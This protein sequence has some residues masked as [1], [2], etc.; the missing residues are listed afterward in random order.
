MLWR[1]SVELLLWKA[2][3][4]AWVNLKLH[5]TPKEPEHLRGPWSERWFGLGAE[6]SA[7]PRPH[8]H[9]GKT[10]TTQIKRRRTHLHLRTD[11]RSEDQLDGGGRTGE[12]SGGP[13]AGLVSS[14]V[15]GPHEATT[16]TKHPPCLKASSLSLC[17]ARLSSPDE[18]S[19]TSTDLLRSFLP[20]PFFVTDSP[21]LPPLHPITSWAA[22]VSSPATARWRRAVSSGP[23]R[24]RCSL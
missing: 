7:R 18:L 2:S 10:S 8:V 23:N 17:L 5:T 12:V 20:P 21:P 19:C 9:A 14:S 4:V 24:R 6:P 15:S 3:P 13:A 11:G 16:V 22:L 1:I